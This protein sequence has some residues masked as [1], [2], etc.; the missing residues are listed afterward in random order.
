M[1]AAETHRR[2]GAAALQGD[3]WTSPGLAGLA[4]PGLLLRPLP[5]QVKAMAAAT[6]RLCWSPDLEA[7]HLAILWKLVIACIPCTADAKEMTTNINTHH[8]H[9][10]MQVALCMRLRCTVRYPIC[11]V[12]ECMRFGAQCRMNSQPALS[13]QNFNAIQGSASCLA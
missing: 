6:T 12:D 11:V 13:Q 5:V 4:V 3:P 1:A 2:A 10:S 9:A 7:E 8:R